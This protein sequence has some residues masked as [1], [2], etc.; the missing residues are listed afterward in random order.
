MTVRGTSEADRAVSATVRYGA[1][2]IDNVLARLSPE[3]L[4]ELP[5]GAI[6]VDRRGTIL[7]YNKAESLISGRDPQRVIGKNFF[8]DIAPCTNRPEFLG[9]FVAGLLSGKLDVRFEYFFDFKMAPAKVSVHLRRSYFDDTVWILVE[10][11][12]SAKDPEA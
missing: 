8:R 2:D 10:R 12:A 1:A 3:Q 9:R 7:L 5:F 4:D 6:K 11:I